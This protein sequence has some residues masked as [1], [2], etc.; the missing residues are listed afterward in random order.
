M[1]SHATVDWAAGGGELDRST[2]KLVSPEERTGVVTILTPTLCICLQP[3]TRL[4]LSPSNMCCACYLR[5]K[6]GTFCVRRT[7]HLRSSLS[8]HLRPPTPTS[9]YLILTCAHLRLP[10]LTSSPTAPNRTHLLL[11]CAHLRPPQLASPSPAPTSTYF[12]PTCAQLR[13][14]PT[15]RPHVWLPLTWAC[16]R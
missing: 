11:T 12:L 6:P 7:S 2:Q 5:F 16:G 10:Q 9:T 4:A 15:H 8:P 14:P 3:G 1:V 13:P